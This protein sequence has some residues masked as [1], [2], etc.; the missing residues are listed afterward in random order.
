MRDYVNKPNKT[1][2][3]SLPVLQY[4][5]FMSGIDCKDQMMAYYPCGKSITVVKNVVCTL[6]TNDTF[7]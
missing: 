7:E 4:N 6:Y 3:K 5:C 1:V 2:N